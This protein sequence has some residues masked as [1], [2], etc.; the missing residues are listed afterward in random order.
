MNKLGLGPAGSF[1]G[2]RSLDH[3]VLLATEYNEDMVEEA[4]LSRYEAMFRTSD[5]DPPTSPTRMA[6]LSR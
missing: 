6:N 5:S 1:I 3:E 2:L 4:L